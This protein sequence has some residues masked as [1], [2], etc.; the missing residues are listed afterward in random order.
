ME[1]RIPGPLITKIR[2]YQMKK[3]IILAVAVVAILT[4]V[5]EAF[6]DIKYVGPYA[7]GGK[8]VNGG[9]R[10]TS[11]DGNPYNNANYLGYND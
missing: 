2:R 9:W 10:D 8:I 6:C 5:S 1:V 7:R 11:H 3:I 4:M